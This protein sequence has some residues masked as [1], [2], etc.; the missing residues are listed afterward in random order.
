ML[1]KK[2]VIS[3]LKII[4][5]QI[6]L[7]LGQNPLIEPKA[8]RGGRSAL[9]VKKFLIVVVLFVALRSMKIGR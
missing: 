6:V 1:I 5:I 8:A 7:P 9:L 2:F 3:L 4:K